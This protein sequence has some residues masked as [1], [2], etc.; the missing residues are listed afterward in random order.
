[1]RYREICVAIACKHPAQGKRLLEIIQ[2]VNYLDIETTSFSSVKNL[3]SSAD[4]FDVIVIAPDLA[5][6]KTLEEIRKFFDTPI[7]TIL[8]KQGYENAMHSDYIKC[9]AVEILSCNNATSTI[10]PAIRHASLQQHHHKS[11]FHL[12]RLAT[13]GTLASSAAHEFNNLHSTMLG[14]IQLVLNSSEISENC[15]TR[16]EVV[17]N[18]T[19]RAN[20]VTKSMLSFTRSK[21]S[22]YAMTDVSEMIQ[23]ALILVN[24]K[25]TNDGVELE[26]EIE[27]TVVALMD[28]QQVQQVVLNLVINASHAVIDVPV[29]R[30]SIIAGTL[31]EAIFI[32]VKDTGKGIEEKYHDKIFDPFFTTKGAHAIKD[33]SYS[34]INGS[35]LGLSVCK[36][37]IEKHNGRI[38]IVSSKNNGA[39]F[40]IWLPLGSLEKNAF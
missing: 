39:V 20:A 6:L 11:I 10:P 19:K 30:V 23:D 29:K 31:G 37:V 3:I 14:Y 21:T 7:I 12:E 9:G 1:M 13:I 17:L 38:D 25:L 24:D 22:S 33:S 2:S 28:K 4:D 27:N 15:K 26:L 34:K 16:L 36:N 18:A 8:P 5:T 40:T 32:Q 35:G